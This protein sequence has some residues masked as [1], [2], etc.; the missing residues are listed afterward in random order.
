MVQ[1]VFLATRALTVLGRVDILLHR[2]INA[3][4]VLEV[5]SSAGPTVA[6][7]SIH[8]DT[9]LQ[10]NFS[11]LGVAVQGSFVETHAIIVPIQGDMWFLKKCNAGGVLEV[12]CSVVRDA[13][14]VVPR[15][16]LTEEGPLNPS[17]LRDLKIH[18][19]EI[20]MLKRLIS[21]IPNSDF[22]DYVTDHVTHVIAHMTNMMM[23]IERRIISLM[24]TTILRTI[25]RT[26]PVTIILMRTMMQP[27]NATNMNSH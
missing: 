12:E 27:S 26:M 17:L 18:L 7:V 8:L 23:I 15:V 22:H 1:D 2:K 16:S 10:R 3:H 9:S 14:I 20:V 4:G 6:I 13:T 11:A 25:L 24:R 21:R 19:L 5:E